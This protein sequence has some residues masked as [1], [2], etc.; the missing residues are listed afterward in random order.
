M[1]RI[2]FSIGDWAEAFKRNQLDYYPKLV[3]T[4]PFT[5]VASDKLFSS[6]HQLA[7]FF[8]LLIAH[9]HQENINSWHILYCH[10]IT[11][12]LPNDIYERNTVQFHW[13]NRGYFTFDDFLIPLLHVKEK[14]PVKKDNL[15]LSKI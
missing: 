7:S 14:T 4:I 8:S 5:P 6:K 1:G 13:F 12:E 10:Q 3:A 9:C 15:S 11:T 2:C